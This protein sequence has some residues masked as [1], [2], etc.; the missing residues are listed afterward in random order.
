MRARRLTVSAVLMASLFACSLS[1][2]EEPSDLSLDVYDCGTLSLYMLLSI[3][4]RPT[5]LKVIESSLPAPHPKGYSM[6]DLREGARLCGL[7]LRGVE[8]GKSVTGLDRPMVVLL[9]RKD[10]GHYVVI[11]PVGHSGKLIQI[12]D[13]NKA[14]AIIDA[15]ILSN[16][17]EWSGLVLLQGDC[18]VSY[19]PNTTLPRYR[20][21]HAAINLLFLM[22]TF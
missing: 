3:E 22:P 8:F 14:P 9:R 18:T 20:V 5:D 12:L 10:H 4:G 16:S 1:F 11:R 6:K 7:S 21:F 17:S 2:A 13:S 19:S 15:D